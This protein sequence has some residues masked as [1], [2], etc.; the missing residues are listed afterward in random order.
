MDVAAFNGS[1]WRARCDDPGP[2]PGDGW[3]LGAKGARGRP[4]ERG[5]PG[6]HVRAIAAVDY[7]LVL[8][9]SDGQALHVDL[10][11]MLEKFEAEQERAAR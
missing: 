4:G 1:E 8:E 9:L 6:V 11:P 3:M 10:K 2:L 7:R 5:P